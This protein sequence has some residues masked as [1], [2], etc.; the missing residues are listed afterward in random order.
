[1]AK[2]NLACSILHVGVNQC[3]ERIVLVL[4]VEHAVKNIVG[5]CVGRLNNIVRKLWAMDEL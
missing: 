1:M 4:M 2:T 3:V 5:T